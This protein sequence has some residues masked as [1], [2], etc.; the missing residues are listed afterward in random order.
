M[1][2]HSNILYAKHRLIFHTYGMQYLKSQCKVCLR[3]F[4]SESRLKRHVKV[5]H[6]GKGAKKCD[7][8][9]KDFLTIKMLNKHKRLMHEITGEHSCYLCG[10]IYQ[11]EAKL[12]A[13]VK[14][15]HRL[16]TSEC[17]ICGRVFKLSGT[18]KRHRRVHFQRDWYITCEFCGKTCRD[19]SNLKIHLLTH[20][21]WRLYQCKIHGCTAAYN[22]KCS[23]ELHY[24]RDHSLTEKEYP[25]ITTAFPYTLEGLTQIIRFPEQFDRYN[26]DNQIS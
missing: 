1:K 5:A 2:F 6:D 7:V 13:H 16:R 22:V 8:C 11:N 24:I 21:S 26:T 19:I 4:E 12:N 25:P 17:D 10:N 15:I 18:M 9:Q 3:I 20:T 23:M 14:S